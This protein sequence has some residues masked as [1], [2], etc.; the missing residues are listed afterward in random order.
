MFIFYSNGQMHDLGF[1][2]G[3]YG[4]NDAAEL[5]GSINTADGLLFHAFLY[6]NGV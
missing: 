3:V 2:G 1:S 4:M 5:T 6:S